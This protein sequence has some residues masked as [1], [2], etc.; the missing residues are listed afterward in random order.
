MSFGKKVARRSKRLVCPTWFSPA[1]HG[2]W[3]QH[4]V[5]LSPACFVSHVA[6]FNG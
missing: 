6:G 2:C 3:R 1:D 4:G 5:L